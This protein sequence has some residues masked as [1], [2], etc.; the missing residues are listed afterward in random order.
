MLSQLQADWLI[1]CLVCS[2][3]GFRIRPSFQGPH[4]RP[5]C[6]SIQHTWQVSAV[7]GVQ[8]YICTNIGGHGPQDVNLIPHG[9]L[10][11]VKRPYDVQ[12]L[13]FHFLRLALCLQLDECLRHHLC[14]HFAFTSF[15]SACS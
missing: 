10:G 4:F 2:L 11:L 5:V 13:P 6:F 15:T 12:V 3:F 9:P 7:V 14:Q 1:V 8:T